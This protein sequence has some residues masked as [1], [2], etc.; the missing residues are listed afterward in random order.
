MTDDVLTFTEGRIGRI[1]LNRPKAIHALDTAMCAAMLEALAGWRG[2]SAI[3]A[4]L[5]DHAAGRGF[6]AGGDIRMIAESGAGDGAEAR[7]FFRT[8]YQLNHALFTYAKPIVAFMDG[9][10]M[11]GGVGISM[12]AKYRV[13]TENTRF[14]M[15]ET[16]IGL[17]PDVGGG[18]YLSRLPGRMGEFIA[19]TGARLDGAEC[20]ALGI[21]THYLPIAALDGAKA[22]I[23][24]DPGSIPSI[25]ESFAVPAPEPKIVAHYEIIDQLFA[26]QTVEGILAALE[27]DG[28]FWS[29][30]QRTTLRTKSPQAMKVSLHLIR[31]GRHM[32]S[33]EDEMRQEFAVASRVVQRPDFAEGVR[34]VIVDK[35]NAPRWQPATVEGVTDHVIDQIF[36]PLPDDQAWT[37][38]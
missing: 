19:L 23:I 27:A 30:A 35:D 15:P 1:R 7:E 25:L 28:S 18:W 20:L 17:F 5:I 37:P 38:A 9:I 36:A 22:K 26:G 14:A 24:A 6:C 21:A 34:A 10:T 32:P 3:E 31:Q 13:A 8:E 4:V 11:G 12:P 29:L 16:G 2:D 33:F